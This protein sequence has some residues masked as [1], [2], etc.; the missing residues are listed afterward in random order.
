MAVSKGFSKFANIVTIVLIILIGLMI[1]LYIADVI[2]SHN[3]MNYLNKF[4]P[5]RNFG[6]YKR[7]KNSKLQ[8]WATSPTADN[9]VKAVN[10]GN[11]ENSMEMQGVSDIS[12][13]DNVVP[14]IGHK[15]KM[16]GGCGCNN[17]F[18]GCGDKGSQIDSLTF[19]PEKFLM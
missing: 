5:I 9:V 17:Y 16:R 8:K 15:L 1:V 10:N 3:N 18:G 11:G 4:D 13:V 12:P 19:Q 14:Q 7:D 6:I 2:L